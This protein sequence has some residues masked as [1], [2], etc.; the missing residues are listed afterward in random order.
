MKVPLKK[1]LTIKNINLMKKSNFFISLMFIF[2][3]YSCGNRNHT[4]DAYGN[5]EAKEIIISAEGSGKI[6]ELNIEEGQTLKA[7]QKIGTID[8][9][10]LWL[11]KEQLIAQKK[12]VVT[13]SANVLSQIDVFKE[14]KNS[15]LIEKQRL[16]KLLQDGAATTKQMDDVVGRIKVL[17]SQMESVRTQ[18]SAVFTELDIILK[19]IEQIDDQLKRCYIVNPIEGTVLTKYAEKFELIATGK[20]LYKIADLTTMELR[21]YVD[22]SQLPNIKLGQ[23][24]KVLIDK[25][26]KQYSELEGE[27]SW[28]SDRG[29]FTPK[30]IQTKKERVNLVYAVKVRVKNDGILKIAMPGEIELN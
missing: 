8:T 19:Q 17:D 26:E 28:I 7:G 15:I 2:L 11:K 29:E 10:Q 30:I 20:A 14:Q 12:S 6:L 24:V 13:K 5:F 3:F 4:S 21:V 23:K 25:D 16:E 22:G 18:N 1:I 27:V 9:V